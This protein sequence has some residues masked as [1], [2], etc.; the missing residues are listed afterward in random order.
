MDRLIFAMPWFD[1][2][3]RGFN[4]TILGRELYPIYQYFLNN[5]NKL[6]ENT[7]HPVFKTGIENLS[8]V[9]YSNQFINRNLETIDTMSSITNDLTSNSFIQLIFNCVLNFSEV[10]FLSQIVSFNKFIFI[11]LLFFI[12]IMKIL[13][14]FLFFFNFI[15]KI[16]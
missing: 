15:F 1:V 4:N 3:W 16:N 13:F 9:S 10:N 7:S 2:N 5:F 14:L 12:S 6:V 8:I 11:I